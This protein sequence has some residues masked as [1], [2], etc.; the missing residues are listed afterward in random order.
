VR[1]I[2]ILFF[3]IF[4]HAHPIN[5]TKM[6]LNLTNNILHVR[7]VSF[8]IEKTYNIEYQN[9]KSIQNDKN[10]IINYTKKHLVFKKCNLIPIDFK[11]SKEIVI[12]EFFILKCENYSKLNI[13]FDMFMNDD[14]TQVGVLKINDKNEIIINFNRNKKNAKIKTSKKTSF[15]SFIKI[16][17]FHILEGIDH[18]TFLLMLLLPAIFYNKT[19]KKSLK[20]ILIIA[21]AFSISHSIALI[22]S[23][24]EMITPNPNLIEILI[25][26]TIFLTALNNLLHF[27]NYKKEWLVAFL[28]GFIHGFAFSEAVRGLEINLK[29]FI[30]IVLGFNL[31]VEIGQ[32]IIVVFITPILFLLIKKVKS[33]YYYLSLLGMLLGS[34]WMID[35]IFGLNYMPF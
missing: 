24:F 8:N 4:L 10:R 33:L 28:F 16:G 5:L 25:A 1:K 14:P 26:F 27:I 21:T 9:E 22:L 11:V 31:G 12:D 20:D 23:A 6:D 29:N 17:I 32:I 34:L 15:I 2:L 3:F 35:R 30:K 19:I 18:I 13:Y 7:F